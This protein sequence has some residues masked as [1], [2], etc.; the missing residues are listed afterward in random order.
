MKSEDGRIGPS[1]HEQ[2]LAGRSAR[3]TQAR[4]AA[5]AGAAATAASV[6]TA[7]S[8]HDAAAEAAAGCV[9]EIDQ[10]G[11]R[12]GGVNGAG[13][14]SQ[15]SVLSSRL[16]GGNAYVSSSFR[17]RYY[18][19][20]SQS[21]I[22]EQHLLLAGQESQLEPAED[23]VHDRLGVADVRITAPATRLKSR[24]RELFAEQFQ[25]HAVLQRD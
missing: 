16:V 8:G 23:V 12:V 2:N 9:S 19:G 11:E 18:A 3:P 10:A 13:S 6:A 25:G 17:L 22:L 20:R 7:V 4:L 15:F 24:V 21:E 14:S 1:L 5:A